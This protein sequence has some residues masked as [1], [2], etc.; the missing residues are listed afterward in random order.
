[1]QNNKD[2]KINRRHFFKSAGIAGLSSVFVS[3]IA[4][5]ADANTPGP[6]EPN[7]PTAPKP[8]KVPARKLGKTGA[9]VPI[10]LSLIHI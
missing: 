5:A 2:K 9:E 10:L 8:E 1:M 6:N 7:A 3:S 4:K